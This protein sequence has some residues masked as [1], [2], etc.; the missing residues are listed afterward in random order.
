MRNA[1]L[2]TMCLALAGPALAAEL[3]AEEMH[4]L[5]LELDDRQRNGGDYKALAYLEQMKKTKPTWCAS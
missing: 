2:L 4:K 5:L 1:M 3:T